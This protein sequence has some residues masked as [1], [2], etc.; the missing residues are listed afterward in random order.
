MAKNRRMTKELC[1]DPYRNTL[2]KASSNEIFAFSIVKNE[3]VMRYMRCK[4]VDVL[5]L[6]KYMVLLTKAVEMKISTTLT[7]KF[8]LALDGWSA[9]ADHYVA[10]F[11]TFYADNTDGFESR[12]LAFSTFFENMSRNSDHH[13]EYLTFVLE[14]YEKTMTDV[15][16]FIAYKYEIVQFLAS[17]E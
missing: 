10:L 15:V 13:I 6:M 1:R 11:A 16:E 14:A 5:T 3:K 2:C 9:G 12:L 17:A 7:D 4:C 8:A